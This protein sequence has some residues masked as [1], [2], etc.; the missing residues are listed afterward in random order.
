MSNFTLFA[1]MRK[2]ILLS[3]LCGF[4]VFSSIKAQKNAIAIQS[5]LMRTLQVWGASQ[6]ITSS[7]GLAFNQG[8]VD[9]HTMTLGWGL[10]N[11]SLGSFGLI[12][13]KKKD[14]NNSSSY[15]KRLAKI[16]F[17]NTL[18]DIGYVTSGFIMSK[19]DNLRTQAFGEAIVIQG[20]VL[21]S[22]DLIACI[23]QYRC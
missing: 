19:S 5:D 22:F 16:Y 17:I 4:S 23:S 2:L 20:G 14:P 18:L 12:N 6:I 3:I 9:F 15:A 7:A 1:Y 13:N 11:T 10:V 21:F 8:N